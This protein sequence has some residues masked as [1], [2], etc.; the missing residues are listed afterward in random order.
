MKLNFEQI[1]SITAGAVR[2]TE[3]DG[4][5]R[6]FRFNEEQTELYRNVR[7]VQERHFFCL[8]VPFLDPD[9]YTTDKRQR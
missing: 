8:R 7:K 4:A 1:K 2:M 3:E 5:I 6:F 9:G